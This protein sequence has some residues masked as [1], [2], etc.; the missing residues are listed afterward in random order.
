MTSRWQLT[1]RRALVTGGT[2]GI[3]W[4]VAEE[5]LTL[6][7]EVLIVA[8]NAEEMAAGVAEWTGRHLP[9]TGLADDVST[10]AGRAAILAAVQARW[11][12]LD[13]LVNNV[14]TNIR[15]KFM[16]YITTEYERLFQ[17]NLFS[18]IEVCRAAYLLLRVAKK[19]SIVNI[20]SVAG[21]LDVGTGTYYSLTKAA[22]EQLG[23]NLAVE[24]AAD[25]I[26]VNTVAPWF[27][28]P[29]LTEELLAQPEFA[30][31]VVARTPLGRVGE[32][33][34]IATAVAFLCL[35]GAAYITGQC[36]LID[37]GLST[38]RIDLLQRI[39]I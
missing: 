9:A 28:R 12:G 7:A 39:A 38:K 4:A 11:Q 35:P 25:G 1:G 2:K 5:L 32:P 30:Q 3:G 20:G 37:G 34:E 8:R 16:D 6:G 23:R 10:A 14:G 24:W 31:K 15:K 27:I 17:I 29:P 22:E 19:A 26:R 21:R 36:L 13:I 18:I 33:E